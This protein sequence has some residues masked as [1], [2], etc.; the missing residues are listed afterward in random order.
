MSSDIFTDCSAFICIDW[1]SI[2]Y[3][4]SF[5]LNPIHSF[6]VVQVCWWIFLAFLYFCLK[7]TLHIWKM[8]L[9]DMECP[10]GRLALQHLDPV[11]PLA[12]GRHGFWREGSC[13]CSLFLLGGA[14]S[15]FL[16]LSDC[17]LSHCGN[18]LLHCGKPHVPCGFLCVYAAWALL[19]FVEFWV[20][21]FIK[22]GKFWPLFLQIIFL[23]PPI[24]PTSVT[25]S[26]Y[27]S[28]CLVFCCGS[29]RLC[30]FI[31]DAFQSVSL[32][33]CCWVLKFTDLFFC[34]V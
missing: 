20:T 19:T 21:V 1:S 25:S 9:L 10:A 29:L 3:Y 15:T 2:R 5:S 24:S 34:S 23:F 27:T 8:L 33:I 28:G 14:L 6:W 4:S 16:F 7:M 13:P 30:L 11:V 17:E 18:E 22:F 26:I 12:P 31:K 32:S